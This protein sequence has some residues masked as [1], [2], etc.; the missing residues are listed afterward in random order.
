MPKIGEEL[1]DAEESLAVEKRVKSFTLRNLSYRE[2]LRAVGRDT[3]I[4]LSA[5]ALLLG[6]RRLYRVLFKGESFKDAF[7]GYL[8]EDL[9]EALEEASKTLFAGAFYIFL[10]KGGIKIFRNISLL[11]VILLV[12]FLSAVLKNIRSLKRG[13]IDGKTFVRI[14]V[15]HTLLTAISLYGTSLGAMVGYHLA[16]ELKSSPLIWSILFG[17]LFG[18]PSEWLGRKLLKLWKLI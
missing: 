14:T 7:R 1:E 11:K 2:A 10:R 9:K 16:K 8:K 15:A 5:V 12:E 4:V 6:I 17:F 18:I 13:E 3:L